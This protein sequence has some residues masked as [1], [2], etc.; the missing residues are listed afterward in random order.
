MEKEVSM[1]VGRGFALAE[2]PMI[3]SVKGGDLGEERTDLCT[4][5]GPCHGAG[6]QLV[7]VIGKAIR[8]SGNRKK[9]EG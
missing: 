7:N 2:L 6:I 1:N 4:N 9:R 3:P 5:K 8:L